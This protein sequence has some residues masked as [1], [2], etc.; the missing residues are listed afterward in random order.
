[1]DLNLL[2][3][4]SLTQIPYWN[5]LRDM[6][7]Q[8]EKAAPELVK[9]ESYGSSGEGRELL[10]MTITDFS[11]GKAEERPA[12]FAMEGIHASELTMTI[13]AF[14]EK[15]I[16][17]HTPGGILSR[18]VFYLIPRMNPDGAEMVLRNS[19][20][21]IRS[22]LPARELRP[23]TLHP[24]DVNG[25]GR[26]LTMLLPT[27]S[28][29][30]VKDPL[31]PRLLIPRTANS[32]GPFYRAIPEGFIHDWDPS[33]EIHTEPIV[34]WNRNW[35]FNWQPKPEHGLLPFSAPEMRATA[36]FLSVHRNIFSAIS[37]HVGGEAILLPPGSETSVIEPF[38]RKI[39][40]AIGM[41]AEECCKLPIYR[42]CDYN[43]PP[44]R[45][46]WPFFERP[47]TF[48]DFCYQHL[49]IPNAD[50]E[51]SGGL[52]ADIG[53]GTAELENLHSWEEYHELNRKLL[54]WYDRQ[55]DAPELYV[56]W[57]KFDHPQLGEVEIG[58]MINLVFNRRCNQACPQETENICNF[59]KKLAHSGPELAFYESS[60]EQVSPGIW[61]IRTTVGNC[62]ELST[63]LTAKAVKNARF[64][65]SILRFNCAPEVELLSREAIRE[66]GELPGFTGKISGEW[67]V[68]VPEE[69][70]LLGTVSVECG[71]AGRKSCQIFK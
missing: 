58:G 33:C 23:N 28:G 29:N 46:L 69:T 68:R 26:I 19:F 17:E 4:Y 40:T 14:A 54:A 67:F 9:V 50:L 71:A 53:I 32:E 13:C 20:G 65:A 70:A 37:I 51:T 61:R 27:P 38:D 8:F 64:P 48:Q 59:F 34:D 36:E 39:L 15:L 56:P 25:D 47:G 42:N 5:D 22:Q 45:W 30:L 16:R 49:G 55:T 41:M 12:F 10:V 18:R 1:M 21:A 7:Y 31:D 6:L 62:G 63:H 3:K 44:F 60:A 11:S 43:I 24:A 52:F 57:Q 66:F 2:P 35:S